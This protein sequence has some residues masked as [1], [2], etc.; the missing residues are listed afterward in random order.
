MAAAS[1]AA[2]WLLPTFPT[3]RSHPACGCVVLRVVRMP[4]SLLPS[5]HRGT[6]RTDCLGAWRSPGKKSSGF[7]GE[8]VFLPPFTATGRSSGC[9]SWVTD[10]PGATVSE[11]LPLEI[12][13][14]EARVF[15]LYHSGQGV[16]GSCASRQLG[17]G[18][19]G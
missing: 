6:L 14:L 17:E 3:S 15:V 12:L 9:A 19:Q 1:I 10:I 7:A 4:F 13:A 18:Q 16:R 8:L 5:H 11:L 2:V